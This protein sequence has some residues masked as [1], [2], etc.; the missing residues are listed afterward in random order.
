MSSATELMAGGLPATLANRLGSD[1]Q[2]AVTAAGTTTADATVCVGEFI[3]IGTAGANTGIRL[4]D[5]GDT[6]VVRNG[7]ASTVK[8]YPPTGSF[9]NGTQDAAFSVTNAKTAIFFRADLRFIG[10]LSA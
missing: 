10:V 6:Y 2:T 4:P 5:G 7:G 9:M 3:E 1:T 8:V